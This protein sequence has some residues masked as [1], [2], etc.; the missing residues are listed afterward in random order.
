[1]PCS[2][3]LCITICTIRSAAFPFPSASVGITSVRR[4]DRV[5][6]RRQLAVVMVA[7]VV[8]QDR[9][10]YRT[11]AVLDTLISVVS[12]RDRTFAPPVHLLTRKPAFRK[13]PSRT[14][15]SG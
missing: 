12:L 3:P 15:T 4:V 8:S 2:G 13:L 5:S 6:A 1:M 14:P 7:I 9:F 11:P 10:C